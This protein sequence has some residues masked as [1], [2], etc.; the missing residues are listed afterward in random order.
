MKEGEA[1]MKKRGK[2]RGNVKSHVEKEGSRE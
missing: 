2:G 1:R